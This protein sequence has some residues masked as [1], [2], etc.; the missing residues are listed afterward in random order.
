M[1]PHELSGNE[2]PTHDGPIDWGLE[3]EHSGEI[4]AF[5]RL[6]TG[7]GGFPLL[8]L[9]YNDPVYRDKVIPYLNLHAK[10]PAVFRPDP[11]SGYADFE[12]RLPELAAGH[13]LIQIVGLS[14]WLTGASRTEKFRG[15]NYHREYL[16]EKAPVAIALWMTENYIRDFA[17][18]APDMWAWRTAV[19]DFA[20]SSRKPVE[21]ELSHLDLGAAKL[22]ERRLRIKEIEDYLAAH[23]RESISKANLLRELGLIYQGIGQIDDALRAL[24]EAAI[25]YRNHRFKREHTFILGDIARIYIDKGDVDEALKLLHEVLAVF[26]QL[27]DRRSRAVTLGDIARIYVSRGNIDGA[28]K[29]LK[30]QF[31]IFEQLGDRRECAL[32]FGEIARVYASRGDLDEALKLHKGSLAVYEQLGDLDGKANSLWSIGRIES[33]NGDLEGARQHL[34]AAY[35]ILLKIGRLDGV[36]TV[37]LDL[38]RLLLSLNETE[39]GAEILQPCEDGFRKLDRDDMARAAGDLLAKAGKFPS[40]TK[41]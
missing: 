32:A 34:S 10:N 17:L 31:E 37:G 24:P 20:V 2:A 15:L 38:G 3:G 12:K 9:Q 22:P 36:C 19:I 39:R 14:E 5:R 6:V 8:V 28:L 40:P 18:Q 25:I 13:D 23:P 16:A 33:A 27:G 1:R 26:E 29:L 21:L 11:Q 30:E 7:R 4:L 35:D 41:K